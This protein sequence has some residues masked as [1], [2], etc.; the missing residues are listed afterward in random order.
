ML[1]LAHDADMSKIDNLKVGVTCYE[2]FFT[3]KEL[4]EMEK[5]VEQTEAKSLQDNYLPMTA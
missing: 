5:H 1:G 3:T 2:N 4:D